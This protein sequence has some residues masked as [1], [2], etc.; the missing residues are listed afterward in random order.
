[1]P[2]NGKIGIDY[3]SSLY[4]E[5]E[6]VTE[7]PQPIYILQRDTVKA[8]LYEKKST[9]SIVDRFLALL[10]VE[11]TIIVTLFTATFT[12]IL[13]LGGENIKGIFICLSLILAVWLIVTIIKMVQVSSKMS[14]DAI[15]DELGKLGTIIQPKQHNDKQIDQ[16]TESVPS[17]PQSIK[18]Y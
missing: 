15:S 2:N 4:N 3:L 10:G 16:E 17:E 14:I 12:S 5:A 1:M 8:F 6:L 7:K 9:I 11:I 13:G 18:A